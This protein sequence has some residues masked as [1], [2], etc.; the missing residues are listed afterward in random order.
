Q[1]R[2][3]LRLQVHEAV[4]ADRFGDGRGQMRLEVG[5]GAV[6]VLALRLGRRRFRFGRGRLF[7]PLSPASQL[8]VERFR[9]RTKQASNVHQYLTEV[10]ES[11]SARSARKSG[12]GSRAW[13]RAERWWPER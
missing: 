12:S 9:S 1:P 3:D 8:L 11:P 2:V 7:G 13:A 10:M 4:I 5:Q 6:E